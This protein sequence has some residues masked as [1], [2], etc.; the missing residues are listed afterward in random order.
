MPCSEEQQLAENRA[1][2]GR[3]PVDASSLGPGTTVVTVPPGTLGS[4]VVVVAGAGAGV[5]VGAG[6]G[7]GI[8]AGVGVKTLPMAMSTSCIVQLERKRA[9][10]FLCSNP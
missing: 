7:V 2:A 1:S 6:A 10:Q 5:G 8:G 9:K 4:G 3:A